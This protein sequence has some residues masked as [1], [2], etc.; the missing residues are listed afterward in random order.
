MIF[1][2]Y[3]VIPETIGEIYEVIS[4][5]KNYTNPV[6]AFLQNTFGEIFS[7]TVK[8]LL[9]LTPLK[10]YDGIINFFGSLTNVI[11]DLFSRRLRNLDETQDEL[12]IAKE[13]FSEINDIEELKFSKKDII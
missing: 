4:F 8:G 7:K 11:I 9:L 6:Q 12:N 13:Q 5:G 2:N 1:F 10:K 3:N